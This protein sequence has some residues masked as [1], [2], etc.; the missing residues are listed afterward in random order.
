MKERDGIKGGGRRGE[1]ESS[2]RRDI[3]TLLLVNIYSRCILNG[4]F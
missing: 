1:R 2:R 3:E 4:L